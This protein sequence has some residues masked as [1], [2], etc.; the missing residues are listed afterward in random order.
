M[1]P[2]QHLSAATMGACDVTESVSYLI[3]GSTASEE[4]HAYVSARRPRASLL[5]ALCSLASELNVDLLDTVWD[6]FLV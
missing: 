3:T 6:S 5:P 2:N 1:G 4:N